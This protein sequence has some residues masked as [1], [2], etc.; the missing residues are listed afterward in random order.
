MD[1]LKDFIYLFIFS[2]REGREKEKEKHQSIASR[3]PPTQTSPATQAC[4]LTGNRTSGYWVHS[5]FFVF[6]NILDWLNEIKG[7][8]I[9]ISS[10]AFCN[11]KLHWE[12]KGAFAGTKHQKRGA[13]VL[14]SEQTLTKPHELKK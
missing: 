12:S 5:F 8:I 13:Q 14:S 1:C 6:S 7:F 4:A 2:E 11:I 10:E 3:T 9:Q